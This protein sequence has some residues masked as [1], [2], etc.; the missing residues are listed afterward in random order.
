VIGCGFSWKYLIGLYGVPGRVRS[1]CD[2]DSMAFIDRF[3]WNH[4]SRH[5]TADDIPSMVA[6]RFTFCCCCCSNDSI[7]QFFNF[8]Q[9]HSREFQT[10][11]IGSRSDYSTVSVGFIPDSTT[12]RIISFYSLIALKI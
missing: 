4:S 7:N 3:S 11:G 9:I 8:V 10:H 12:T 1:H 5:S 2:D 6:G